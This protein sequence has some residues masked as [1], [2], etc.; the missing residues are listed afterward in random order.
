MKVSFYMQYVLVFP[1]NTC[2]SKLTVTDFRLPK[3]VGWTQIR[4]R[5]PYTSTTKMKGRGD[6]EVNDMAQR[7]SIWCCTFTWHRG[8]P[9][10]AALLHDIEGIHMVLHYYRQQLLRDGWVF[11]W[12]F[13][14]LVCPSFSVLLLLPL[15]QLLG[16]N[17]CRVYTLE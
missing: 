16:A 10:G 2:F 5:H 17:N 8:N 7:E 12:C 9:Y 15:H 3:K 4:C 14:Q 6:V 13:Y 11:T 1:G